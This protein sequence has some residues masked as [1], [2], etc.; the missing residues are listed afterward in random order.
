MEKPTY[1]K[2]V[3][4]PLKLNTWYAVGESRRQFQIWT[5]FDINVKIVERHFKIA[6]HH[7]KSIEICTDMPSIGIVVIKIGL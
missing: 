3:W 7:V 1:G 6:N 2:D 4:K 5:T